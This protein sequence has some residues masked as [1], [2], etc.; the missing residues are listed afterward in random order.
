VELKMNL[1]EKNY[2]C[3]FHSR[4]FPKRK[5]ALASRTS[6]GHT[7]SNIKPN[8]AFN[9]CLLNSANNKFPLKNNSFILQNTTRSKNEAI[10]T[11]NITNYDPEKWTKFMLF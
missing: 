7:D 11:L 4:R 8:A 3:I 10:F 2:T 5:K 1:Q 9:I 6:N